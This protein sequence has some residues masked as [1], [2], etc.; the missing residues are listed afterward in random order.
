MTLLYLST[1]RIDI[2]LATHELTSY[3]TKPNEFSWKKLI[4]VGRYLVS[5][6]RSGTRM[7]L[8]SNSR[9]GVI[10]LRCVSD[11]DW[12]S[13]KTTRRSRACALFYADGCLL[14]GLVRYQSF[15]ALSSGE[16]EFGA[17]H[18]ANLEGLGY[19][20]LFEFMGFRVK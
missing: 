14:A 2:L 8:D 20:Y 4:R 18:T 16:A 9:E 6:R 1:D 19:K 12:A 15:I 13:D 3:I 5:H 10:N 7:K 17:Q 11:S